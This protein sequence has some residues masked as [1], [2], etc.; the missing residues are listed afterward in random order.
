M[1]DDD[2]SEEEI[3]IQPEIKINFNSTMIRNPQNKMSIK[4]HTINTPSDSFYDSFHEE[5]V[6]PFRIA[7]PQITRLTPKGKNVP[8]IAKGL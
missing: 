5:R 2:E 4:T 6:G 7:K 8:N 3:K 1:M